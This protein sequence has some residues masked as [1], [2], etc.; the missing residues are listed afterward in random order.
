M[1]FVKG[2]SGNPG[3][4]PKTVGEVQD[5]ARKYTKE[6]FAGIVALAESAEDESVQ[7]R[8]RQMIHEIGWG[9]PAQQLQHTGAEGAPLAITWISPEAA[10]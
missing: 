5:L 3:G 1:P 7:L 8:A 10:T 6:N 9:K 2:K 4:R